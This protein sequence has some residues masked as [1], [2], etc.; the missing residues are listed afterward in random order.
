M[1]NKNKT[2]MW[3][4]T[5]SNH[6]LVQ[7][8]IL[9]YNQKIR[10]IYG[11]FVEGNTKHC[12]Y[13]GKSNNIYKRMFGGHGHITKLIKGIHTNS[14]LKGAMGSDPLYQK[15]YVEVLKEVPYQF[16]NYYK[17][18]QRLASAEN[19][20]IDYYQDLDQCLHQVP[21]GTAM[22]KTSWKQKNI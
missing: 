11:I 5:N 15:I 4:Q 14:V 16:D 17:D 19:Y 22:N 3:L 2:I 7:N 12:V 8:N 20:Y 9:D 10:G 18:M 6:I 1:E 21:E 13:V